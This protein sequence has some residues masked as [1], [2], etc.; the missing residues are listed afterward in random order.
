[1]CNFDSHFPIIMYPGSQLSYTEMNTLDLQASNHDH[2]SFNS[3]AHSWTKFNEL[4]ARLE[5][6]RL[7]FSRSRSPMANKSN[8]SASK[9]NLN[10]QRHQMYSKDALFSNIPFSIECPDQSEKLNQEAPSEHYL[11]IEAQRLAQIIT[12]TREHFDNKCD[13]VF[14]D[15]QTLLEECCR[16]EAKLVGQLDQNYYQILQLLE[17]ERKNR[18]TQIELFFKMLRSY[19][20]L[21]AVHLTQE[22]DSGLSWIYSS[23]FSDIID[24][25]KRVPISKIQNLV[26]NKDLF[27][28]SIDQLKSKVENLTENITESA[29][30]IQNFPGIQEASKNILSFQCTRDSIV[31]QK[32]D[33]R[34]ALKADL[35]TDLARTLTENLKSAKSLKPML[36]QFTYNACTEFLDSQQRFLDACSNTSPSNL[37]SR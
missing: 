34:E 9:F 27:Y 18:L 10:S 21:D 32:C 33:F 13:G 16:L 31:I 17:D 29:I 12:E 3:Q 14:S 20:N 8:K 6:M 22:F 15:F 35:L 19:V 11:T 5:E 7:H 25:G 37:P 36:A 1:M 4:I 26:E 28:Q 24:P 2:T 30:L 23:D